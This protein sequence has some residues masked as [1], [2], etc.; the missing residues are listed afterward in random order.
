MIVRIR[1]NTM[2]NK[3]PVVYK[4]TVKTGDSAID[5]H[6]LDN[7]DCAKLYNDDMFQVIGRGQLSFHLSV[8]ELIYILMKKLPLCR[9]KEL[10]FSLGI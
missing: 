3:Y 5:Q 7:Q 4:N 2:K 1:K 10:V 6:L 9:Q 8:L